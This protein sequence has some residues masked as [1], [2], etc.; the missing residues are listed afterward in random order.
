[1]KQNKILGA[2]IIAALSLGGVSYTQAGT[3][4][5]TNINNNAPP[6]D[7]FEVPAELFSGAS[8]GPVP[9]S[10]DII[11]EYILEKTID[12]DVF[13]AFE[14]LNST[15]QE[16]SYTAE[17]LQITPT[18]GKTKPSSTIVERTP[19]KLMFSVG[20]GSEPLFATNTMTLKFSLQ[21]EGV[22]LLADAGTEVKL[23]VE[24][25]AVGD[26][27]KSPRESSK[28]IPIVKSQTGVDLHFSL[29]GLNSQID[30]AEGA[31][32]FVNSVDP[33]AAIL[34]KMGLEV[35]TALKDLTF[36]T[37]W[38]WTD[39][40]ETGTLIVKP[41]PFSASV[42]HL[43]DPADAPKLVFIDVGSNSCVYDDGVDLPAT[44]V[45]SEGE[46]YVAQWEL[47]VGDTAEAG[48]EDLNTDIANNAICVAV[49]EGNQTIIEPTENVPEMLLT[50]DFAGKDQY[51]KKL[52]HI[53]R[54]GTVCHL[55]NIPNP[56][57]IDNVNIR[58]TNISGREGNL[59]QG[60]MRDQ[61]DNV[62]FQ[63]VDL[64]E[65]GTIAPKATKVFNITK[66]VEL[67]TANGGKDTWP[68]RAVLTITSDLTSME[69]FGLL[70][71]K[72]TDG[73]IAPLMNMSLGATG[74][75]CGN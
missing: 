46:S 65:G 29:D 28:T 43:P 15:W 23:S 54:N 44:S 27:N 9:S 70:R 35:D 64:L 47:L 59:V 10:G 62:I 61:D 60:S 75:G 36:S 57:A 53:K 21:G 45:S 72:T 5:L 19:T 66:L 18:A 51:S 73:S 69:V 48:V 4:K 3:F 68:A 25:Y 26:P 39:A 74:S 22:A 33:K 8:E 50:L 71:A 16:T 12:K 34:G 42:S 37:G 11:V 14:L 55:Y 58:L 6:A 63:D 41:G 49:E 31:K 32:L 1:M 24:I 17:S 13:V 56:D 30:V 40:F 38:D 7:G 20:T 52:H 2:A 67:S